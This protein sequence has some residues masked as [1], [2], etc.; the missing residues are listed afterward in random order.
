MGEDQSLQNQSPKKKR[1]TIVGLGNGPDALTL[2]AERAMMEA[3]SLV[4]RTGQ[5]AVATWLAGRRAV[6]HTLDALYA[7]CADFDQLC[8]RAAFALLERLEAHD[9]LCYAVCDPGE[10]ATV[11]RLIAA[12][13]EQVSLRVLPCVPASACLQAAA[14]AEGQGF[15]AHRVAAATEL[16]RLQQDPGLPLC[17][18][19]IDSRL[20]ASQVKLWLM[21]RYPPQAEVF[22][23]ISEK[24]DPCALK[25]IPLEELDRQPAYSHLAALWVP[26]MDVSLPLRER[27]GFADLVRIMQTLRGP[28]GCPWDR[29]Q[30]H[31][32]LRQH[33]IEEAYEAVDAVNSG[34]PDALADELGDVLLQ[35]VFHAS[36]GA[37]H[38]AFAIDDVTSNICRKLISRHAHIFG[39]AHCDTADEVQRSW[40]EIKRRE[41]GQTTQAE[42]LGAV[43]KYLPALMRAAKVQKKAANVG[44]D[45]ERAQDALDK[46]LEEAAELRAELEAGADPQEEAGD[47]LFAAVNALRL[48]GVQPELAL[49]AATE[50]FVDRFARMEQMILRENRRL[51]G[52]TLPQMDVYWERAK[53]EESKN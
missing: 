29:E 50:K 46:V 22:F 30:T 24:G 32:S 10:D 41:R 3:G 35:V 49:S 17:V 25:G 16:P 4:L 44:F 39:D 43:P 53:R 27:F 26:A 48:A 13:P 37:Q 47:L 38:G 19:E 40:D 2:G 21:E 31:R 1:L 18:I 12:L 7:E 14:L 15:G 9:S 36:I 52:L 45:W 11:E 8:E 28:G 20:L 5:H 42:A 33:L 34:D 6:F 23:S 51:E